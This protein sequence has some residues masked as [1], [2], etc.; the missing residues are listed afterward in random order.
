[1]LGGVVAM[2]ILQTFGFQNT[3]K[4]DRYGNRNALVLGGSSA[5]S[6][7]LICA[8][9]LLVYAGARELFIAYSMSSALLLI[10]RWSIIVYL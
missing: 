9:A 4:S 8:F 6:Y 3:G 2:S 1:M 10:F 7:G 5:E